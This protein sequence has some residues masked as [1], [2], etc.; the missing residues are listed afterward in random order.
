MIIPEQAHQS[1]SRLPHS[2]L[3]S[4]HAQLVLRRLSKKRT[5]SSEPSASPNPKSEHGPVLPQH[6]SRPSSL[7]T[8]PILSPHHPSERKTHNATH[9]ESY[10]PA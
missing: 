6:R 1:S 7:R 9:S 5:S 3:E 2:H 10:N 8:T 4:P